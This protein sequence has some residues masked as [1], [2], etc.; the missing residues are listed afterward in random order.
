MAAPR[1]DPDADALSYSWSFVQRPSGSAASFDLR[2]PVAPTFVA[3][4]PGVY[5]VSLTVRDGITDS[6][7]SIVT[8]GTVNAAPTANAGSDQSV[9]LTA[10]VQLTGA[11]SSDP[12]GDVLTFAWIAPGVVTHTTN[13]AC[14]AVDGVLKA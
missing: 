7:P 8:I 11:A 3:A 5:V 6:E 4:R 12:D 9:T 14:Q 2:N 10:T 13:E 1:S